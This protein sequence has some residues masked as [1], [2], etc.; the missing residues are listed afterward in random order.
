MGNN[1]LLKIFEEKEC[2]YNYLP[3]LKV[4]MEIIF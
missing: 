3:F 1:Y 2:I 4:K